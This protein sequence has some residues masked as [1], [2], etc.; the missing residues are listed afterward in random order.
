MAST[1]SLT[2]GGE[3]GRGGGLGLAG[4]GGGMEGL[5]QLIHTRWCVLHTRKPMCAFQQASCE[6]HLKEQRTAQRAAS[7]LA[8]HPSP[9]S[10]GHMTVVHFPTTQ[11]AHGPMGFATNV[12]GEVD[13]GPVVFG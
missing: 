11:C 13:H 1:V 7:H 4:G 3:G 2:D 8:Q 12:E 6:D 5:I 10:V 9:A